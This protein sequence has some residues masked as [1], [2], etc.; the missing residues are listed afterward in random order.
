MNVG[1]PQSIWP[2]KVLELPGPQRWEKFWK[3]QAK[4]GL[5]RNDPYFTGTGL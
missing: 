5:E 2:G 3:V 1:F 4:T